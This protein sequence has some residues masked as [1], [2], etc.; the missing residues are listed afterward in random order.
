MKGN[1]SFDK[2]PTSSSKIPF[3]VEEELYYKRIFIIKEKDPFKNIH[4]CQQYITNDYQIFGELPD[5]SK[6]LL[7]IV[8]EHFECKCCECDGWGINFLCFSLICCDKMLFQL[9]YK[10]NNK[11]FYTQGYYQSKGCHICSN[12]YECNFCCCCPYHTLYLRENIDHNN[13]DFNVGIKK[14]KTIT[15]KNI[16][17][18]DR[19]SLYITEDNSK[20]YG[21]RAKCCE[22]CR[23]KCLK[24]Y[25]KY[26]TCDFEIEIENEKGNKC[27]NIYLYSGICSKVVE[28]TCCY[29]PKPYFEINMPPN[30]SSAQKFQIIA[31]TIHFDYV[32]NLL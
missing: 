30:I 6:K 27:G 5:K 4:I 22:I 11:G 12:C 29:F 19:T 25:F 24:K 9:D 13:P 20:G 2:L 26:I 1:R 7:F 18:T 28:D 17:C 16:C 3:N 8:S 10:K 15:S 31:D 21:I 14:G 23:H 32:N